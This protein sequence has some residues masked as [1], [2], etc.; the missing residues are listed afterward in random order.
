MQAIGLA[1]RYP[2][3]S[4]SVSAM[5]MRGGKKSKLLKLA[6]GALVGWQLFKLWQDSRQDDDGR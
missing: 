3:I 5:F 6:G 2:L 1:R 4:S